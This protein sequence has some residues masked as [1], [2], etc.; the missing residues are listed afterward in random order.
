MDPLEDSRLFAT[1]LVCLGHTVPV[2]LY[3]IVTTVSDCIPSVRARF[4]IDPTSHSNLL[5]KWIISSVI[6]GRSPTTTTA[7]TPAPSSSGATTT[8]KEELVATELQSFKDC[9][10]HFLLDHFVISPCLIYFLL[11]P[12]MRSLQKSRVDLSQLP[13]VTTVLRHVLVCAVAEDFF[14]YWIH[15]VLA[16]NGRLYAR[17][18][19]MHHRFNQPIPMSSSFAH[20]LETIV[21]NFLPVFAGS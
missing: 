9:A 12:R 13:A 3:F 2:A 8:V 16:H 7:K 11:W 21:G 19:K 4:K 1:F 20:P 6:G 5:S 18:H 14:F 17:F 10:V 15:R